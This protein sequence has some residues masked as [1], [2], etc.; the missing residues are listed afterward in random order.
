MAD[1]AHTTD[2][3]QT[4]GRFAELCDL[5]AAQIA[6]AQDGS[7]AQVEQLCVRAGDIVAEMTETGAHRNAPASQR[8]RLGQLYEELVLM[9]HA[10][11]ADVEARLKKLRQVKRAVGAYGGRAKS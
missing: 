10:E 3:A 2:A 4:S 9:L 1:D 7:F 11:H 6:C 8:I 5:L